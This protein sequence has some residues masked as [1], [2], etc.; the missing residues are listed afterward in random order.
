MFFISKLGAFCLPGFV[1]ASCGPLA[2]E[3]RRLYCRIETCCFHG[4]GPVTAAVRRA[5][6]GGLSCFVPGSKC[7]E[8]SRRRACWSI[9]Y[10]PAVGSSPGISS[11]RSMFCGS[12][13]FALRHASSVV[14]IAQCVSLL[15]CVVT[16]CSAACLHR[17]CRAS[18][19]ST[20]EWLPSA[21]VNL[22]LVAIVMMMMM[23][24]LLY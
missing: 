7:P 4:G 22:L 8:R 3:T 10:F 1:L 11:S 6:S 20:R 18:E 23:R 21:L 15:A 5:C 9:G 19:A 17:S 24:R 16:G 13:V 14:V 12:I 2:C